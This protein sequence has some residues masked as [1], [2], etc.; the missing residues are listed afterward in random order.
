M[1]N[2]RKANKTDSREIFD[3]RNDQLTR[4]MSHTSDVVEWEGHNNWFSTSITNQN[5]LLLICEEDTTTE[6]VAVVMFDIENDRALISINLSPKMRGK[7]KAKGCLR[8][9]IEFFKNAY[10]KVGL[11]DAEIKSANIASQRSFAGVG[12]AIVREEVNLL[13]FE[14]KI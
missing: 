3:W 2:I 1:P 11:I 6:K 13:F 10:P 12:F 14:Y 7:G 9:A 8:D 5:R 4:Q